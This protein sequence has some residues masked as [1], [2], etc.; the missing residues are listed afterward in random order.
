MIRA[1]LFDF[2]GLLL[3]TES[4]CYRAWCEVYEQHGHEL[5]FTDWSAAIGTVGGFDAA[6]HLAALIGA[7]L[8]EDV[9]EAKRV[10]ELDLC[11]LE[12][13]RPGV[14]E[15]LDEAE[16]RGLA[17]AI[18]S[19]ASEDWI[20]RHLERRGLLDRFDTVVAANGDRHRAKPR[21]TLYLEALARLGLPASAAVA[22]E[23]SPN[24][25]AAAKAAA[26]LCV[27]VPNEITRALDLSAADVVLVSLEEVDLD[28]LA[29]SLAAA[30]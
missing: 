25:V 28:R 13:L 30:A 19:S 21:P 10:R 14:A 20:G 29:R 4:P 24:G 6:G 5:A 27:A 2:D 12:E 26:L 1:L 8:A 11:D 7:E 16:V 23:D 17:T 18:V 9:R 3:D 15:L 22:F